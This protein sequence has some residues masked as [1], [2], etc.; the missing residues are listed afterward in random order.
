MNVDLLN[1]G[2]AAS[3]AQSD[4][5]AFGVS[6]ELLNLNTPPPFTSSA[7]KSGGGNDLLQDLFQPFNVNQPPAAPEAPA[8]NPFFTLD[9]FDPLAGLAPP[10]SQMTTSSS[11]G[12]FGSAQQSPQ[13][14]SGK[15]EEESLMGNWDSILK[16]GPVPPGNIPRNASFPN[17]QQQQQPNIRPDPLAAFGNLGSFGEPTRVPMNPPRGPPTKPIPPMNIGKFPI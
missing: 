14:G 15:V 16:P 11:F 2:S 8:P 3:N 4:H 5:S 17:L 13:S 10:P 6:E 1:L 7:T 9:P 12:N